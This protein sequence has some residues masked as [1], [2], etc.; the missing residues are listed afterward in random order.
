MLEGEEES[1][2]CATS[3][4]TWMTDATYIANPVMLGR[5][6]MSGRMVDRKAVAMLRAMVACLTASSAERRTSL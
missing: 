6:E 4:F 3:D 2:R 5:R 1:F